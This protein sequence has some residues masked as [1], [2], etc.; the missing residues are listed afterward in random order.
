M[1][2]KLKRLARRFLS[3]PSGTRFQARY[4]RLQQRPRLARTVLAGG[5][6]L[7]LLALGLI[8][9]VLPG[10][11]LLVAAIG[12]ALIAGESLTLA[13]VLDRIDLSLT[14]LR[15]RWRR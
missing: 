8:L 14:R 11:G 6:G 7:L 5:L 3:A 15:A 9:L 1:W 2:R 13:R 4:V 12:L 10:P